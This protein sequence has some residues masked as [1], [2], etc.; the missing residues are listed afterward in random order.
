MQVDRLSLMIIIV[1]LCFQR[2][3]AALS[4]C[5]PAPQTPSNF[6][7]KACSKIPPHESLNLLS[8][9]STASLDL[10]SFVKPRFESNREGLVGQ[11]EIYARAPDRNVLY[12]CALVYSP[13]SWSPWLILQRKKADESTPSSLCLLVA[14][15]LVLIIAHALLMYAGEL[16]SIETQLDRSYTTRRLELTFAALR[17]SLTP[18]LVAQTPS[19][20]PPETTSR[21]GVRFSA[22]FARRKKGDDPAPD[23]VDT[24]ITPAIPETV[25]PVDGTAADSHF[26]N[27]TVPPAG[28]FRPGRITLSGSKVRVK[29]RPG[30][31]N[32][33]KR[34]RP[35]LRRF[36]R[37]AAVMANVGAS[38]AEAV[39]VLGAPVKGTLEACTKVQ[40]ILERRFQNVEAIQQLVSKLKDLEEQLCNHSKSPLDDWLIVRL[41]ETE[42]ELQ[43]LAARNGLD[44]EHV[45]MSITQCERDIT[46]FMDRHS[47]GT[48][49]TIEHQ[50]ADIKHQIEEVKRQ[51]EANTARLVQAILASQVA[52]QGP[53][54]LSFS[55]WVVDPFGV[56]HLFLQIPCSFDALAQD[57]LF[58]YDKDERRRPILER[59]LEHRLFELSRDSGKAV[60]LVSEEDLTTL[61]KDSTL[62]MSVI[63]FRTIT[64][65][66]IQCPLCK[67]YIVISLEGFERVYCKTCDKNVQ[68]GRGDDEWD[69][70]DET[71]D[72]EDLLP[73]MR[74]IVIKAMGVSDAMS[75]GIDPLVS[76]SSSMDS[77]PQLQ[78][79][80][81][82][83]LVPPAPMP[84][85]APS[86]NRSL[87]VLHGVTLDT[88]RIGPRGTKLKMRIDLKVIPE[89]EFHL[90][91]SSFFEMGGRAAFAPVASGGY[92]D[93]YKAKMKGRD[94]KEKYVVAKVFRNAHLKYG[95]S[96]EDKVEYIERL[97]REYAV[98]SLLR[99]PNILPLIG[100]VIHKN[101][102]SPGLVSDYKE[103]RDLFSFSKVNPN[104]DR[105]HM[106]RGI[107]CGLE[108]L[109]RMGVV[110][111]DLKIV[112]ILV[113]QETKHNGR[114]SFFPLIADFGTSRVLEKEGYI[115]RASTQMLYAP[116]EVLEFDG[117]GR[118]TTSILTPA[119]DVYSFALV[120][121]RSTYA[122]PYW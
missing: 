25:A 59:F 40:T 72:G 68:V 8:A 47:L 88:L 37:R 98:W 100:L 83:G 111:G 2:S 5:T 101:L 65:E 81:Q 46:F 21:M 24:G 79:S 51:G 30:A 95:D 107:A 94:G 116:P 50:N 78:S 13:D 17:S 42:I 122:L 109:H 26:P 93:I 106:G 38:V 99:H 102:S 82:T 85:T 6:T 3:P 64:V 32:K 67:Q 48:L 29:Q 104:Y 7:V 43:Q 66:G 55:I 61:E 84:S 49:R 115:T 90:I 114:V 45:A 69:E 77:R 36:G 86:G 89:T 76:A 39:P 57:L 20:P 71:I 4:P 112:D 119:S 23:V 87:D 41:D 54:L 12:T 110:H 75:N 19:H 52:N 33:T 28:N 62:V 60:A 58:R 15:L 91:E 10:P 118:P 44:Y 35:A 80:S 22:I 1:A 16:P 96:D 11:L 73:E 34:W 56:K 120:L 9:V 113:D 53:V 63:A 92:A 103:H 105:L 97:R 74:Q 117:P 14:P 18:F 27:D 108:Y 121:L 70:G 31:V